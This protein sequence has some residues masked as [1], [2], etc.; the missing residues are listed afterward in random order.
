MR[1]LFVVMVFAMLLGGCAP[2]VTYRAE[3][4]AKTF[5]MVVDGKAYQAQGAAFAYKSQDYEIFFVIYPKFIAVTLVNNSDKVIRLNWDE[6]A[7]ILP[8]GKTSR[9][10]PGAT[11]WID[12]NQPK[13][14][15]II[16]PKSKLEDG[17]YP[18]EN[19]YF[20]EGFNFVDMF[21]YPIKTET[22][23]RLFIAL[24]VG[25]QPQRLEVLFTAKPN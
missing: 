18:L 14:P 13:P 1:N 2:T 11:S 21:A 15:A 12:R 9:V 24:S 19:A 8:N 6:S 23:I 10:V 20:Y 25:D 16:P 22:N 17:F 4:G 7:M 3:D 5:T